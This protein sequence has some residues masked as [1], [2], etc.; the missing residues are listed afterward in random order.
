MKAKK[1]SLPPT[2]GLYFWYKMS[3][4]VFTKSVPCSFQSLKIQARHDFS[5]KWRLGAMRK[6]NTVD[7]CFGAYSLA[8]LNNVSKFFSLGN[9]LSGCAQ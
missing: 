3:G 8:A 6:L 7:S 5:S 2:A 1:S 9:M 4:G